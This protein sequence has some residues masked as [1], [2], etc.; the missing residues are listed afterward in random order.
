MNTCAHA[1]CH[2]RV[3]ALVI[4]AAGSQGSYVVKR[5]EWTSHWRVMIP[6]AECCS[7]TWHKI[8]KFR[9]ALAHVWYHLCD[10]AGCHHSCG[11][12]MRKER[13]VK[14]RQIMNCKWLM[15][16]FKGLPSCNLAINLRPAGCI[17][18]P[19]AQREAAA[20]QECICPCQ[21][22]A[23]PLDFWNGG[24]AEA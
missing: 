12:A 3:Q 17:L 19:N 16:S 11:S 1:H 18:A 7:L 4:N 24:L 6:T 23:L 14:R 15:A 22:V 10:Q 5:Q 2:S 13:T 20:A 8:H 21:G 9:A